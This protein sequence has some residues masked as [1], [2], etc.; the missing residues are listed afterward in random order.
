MIWGRSFEEAYF[1]ENSFKAPYI[2]DYLIRETAYRS[3]H[4]D[5]SK[6]LSASP[7]YSS[8]SMVSNAL[9]IK[10]RADS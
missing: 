8:R 10:T 7:L 2:S 3:N 4:V 1:G 6:R 9:S 5:K